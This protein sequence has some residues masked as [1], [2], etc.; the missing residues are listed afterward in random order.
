M[1][2]VKFDEME[3]YS[4]S[5]GGNWFSLKDDGEVKKV[6]F[7]FDS[8]D[9]LPIRVHDV[10]VGENY[11]SVVCLRDYDDPMHKCP[12]CEEGNIARVKLFIPLHDETDGN[13]KFWQRPKSFGTKIASQ[14]SRHRDFPSHLFEVERHG[15]AGDKQT[16]YELFEV[17]QDDKKLADFEVPDAIGT[18]IMNKSAED[19]EYYLDNGDFP[20]DETSQKSSR[21]EER[22]ERIT[23]RTPARSDR[24]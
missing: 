7:L 22:T 24:F 12:L 14:F 6:R 1:A 4:V 19:M 11:R 16:T 9:D 5:T 8:L 20:G 17:D 23:R 18:V 21:E 2:R 3:K 15:K 10:K 13:V